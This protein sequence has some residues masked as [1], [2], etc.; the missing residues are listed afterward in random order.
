MD[1]RRGSTQTV[2]QKFPLAPIFFNRLRHGILQQLHRHLHRY[3]LPSPNTL[4]D[5]IPKLAIRSI[6]LGAQEIPGR[7]MNEGEIAHQE[8]ALR[9]LARSGAAEDENHRNGC[10]VERWSRLGRGGERGRGGGGGGGDD[11]HGADRFREGL[12]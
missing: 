12:W 10:R 5:H 7:Q 4:F 3:N 8:R 6:L 11:G 1:R 9:S 2:N